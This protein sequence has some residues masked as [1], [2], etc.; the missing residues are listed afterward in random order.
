MH[1]LLREMHRARRIGRTANL[2]SDPTRPS[3]CP[4]SDDCL[5]PV[6]ETPALR[7]TG[8]RGRSSVCRIC[9]TTDNILRTYPLQVGAQE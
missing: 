8:Q 2:F 5:H 7:Q 4:G 6:A 1:V 9:S 3:Q